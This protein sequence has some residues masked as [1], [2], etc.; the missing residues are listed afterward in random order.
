MLLPG[1]LQQCLLIPDEAREQMRPI[2]RRSAGKDSVEVFRIPL[3]F[4]QSLAAAIGTS[5]KIAQR[6]VAAIE[7]ADDG[8]GLNAR[9]MYG[10]IA[11]VDELFGMTY[12]PGCARAAFVAV[13]GRSGRITSSQRIDH[14]CDIQCSRPSRRFLLADTCRSSRQREAIRRT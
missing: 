2:A 5:G 6:S 3:R 4:H 1:L 11:E 10:T 8:F 7:R 12:G 14:S 9:F 13:I